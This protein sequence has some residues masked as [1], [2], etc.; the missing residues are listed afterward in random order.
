MTQRLSQG[1]N[2]PKTPDELFCRSCH[3]R[4]H[5]QHASKVN[6]ENVTQNAGNLR[7]AK[8]MGPSAAEYLREYR[9]RAGLSL[10]DLARAAGYK[11]AS[12][13]QRYED[14]EYKRDYFPIELVRRLAPALVG[15]GNP[16]IE[17]EEFY[18]D[19]A[20]FQVIVEPYSGE[21]ARVSGVTFIPELDV[22]AACGLD[23]SLVEITEDNQG[24]HIVAQYGFPTD[25][26]PKVFGARPHHVRMLEVVGDSMQPTLFPG[27]KVMVDLSDNRPT[28]PGIF[29][30]WDGLGLVMKRIEYV[31]HSDPPAVRITSDNARYE[32]YERLLGEAHILGR[33]IGAWGR[34]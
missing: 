17:E 26:F 27:Q 20:G 3:T 4:K 14:P 10:N 28:P 12:S 16:P 33:V 34:L 15:K 2:P 22:R 11:G 25:A 18:R 24:E 1:A 9:T 7:M 21:P 8:R 31:P 30:I 6:V 19:L 29:V 23:G 5:T 32:P 13:L